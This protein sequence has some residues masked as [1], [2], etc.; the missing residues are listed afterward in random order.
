LKDA[1]LP[2]RFSAGDSFALTGP[3]TVVIFKSNIAGQTVDIS[4]A[5]IQ[6]AIAPHYPDEEPILID[7]TS[8]P[9]GEDVSFWESGMRVIRQGVERLYAPRIDD[10]TPHHISL[11]ALGPMPLLAYLG[12]Q[13]S[14]KIPVDLY[15][16]HRDT[17]DWTWKTSGE[18]VNYTIKTLRQKDDPSRVALLLSLSGTIHLTMLPADIDDHFSIYEITPVGI[19]PN[20]NYLRLRQDLIG[21]QRI[22]Q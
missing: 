16:R 15:Q 9:D 7:L 17:E 11:F 10:K 2:H 22:Y 5:H 12:S 13:L 6:E 18:S 8:I 1:G 19:D 20:V 14:N 3:T 4:E 21:F